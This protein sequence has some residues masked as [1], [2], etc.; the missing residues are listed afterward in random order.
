MHHTRD[1]N[2][3]D[4]DW[5][6]AR[7]LAPDTSSSAWTEDYAEVFAALFGP[8]FDDWRAP[9]SRPSP[10]DLEELRRRFFPFGEL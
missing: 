10:E 9:T 5:L 6:R 7:G 3:L 2:D 4:E 8:D 1:A